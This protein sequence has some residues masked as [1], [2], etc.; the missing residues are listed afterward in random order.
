[1]AK[2]CSSRDAASPRDGRMTLRAPC[3]SAPWATG[4]KTCVCMSPAGG[5]GAGGGGSERQTDHATG[6][7]EKQVGSGQPSSNAN[8]TCRCVAALASIFSAGSSYLPLSLAVSHTHP[9]LHASTPPKTILSS[10]PYPSLLPPGYSPP[11]ATC[12]SLNSPGGL[13][14]SPRKKPCAEPSPPGQG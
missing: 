5:G 12:F 7:R 11:R 9:T 1:M 2:A 8:M 4:M 13:G 6:A 3:E 10:E 14:L